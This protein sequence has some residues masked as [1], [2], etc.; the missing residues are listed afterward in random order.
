M[1]VTCKSC[2]RC[3]KHYSRQLGWKRGIAWCG[4]PVCSKELSLYYEKHFKDKVIKMKATKA[5]NKA[6]KEMILNK[7]LA[8]LRVARERKKFRKPYEEKTWLIFFNILDLPKEIIEEAF[9]EYGPETIIESEDYFANFS[10]MY[11]GFKSK[12][13]ALAAIDALK[14][15]QMLTYVFWVVQ[16]VEIGDLFFDNP[17][18]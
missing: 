4:D 13:L 9:E 6:R 8:A 15:P 14:N 18:I 17:C 10:W 7:R 16:G 12:S 11:V 1:I 5:E 2:N 3:A